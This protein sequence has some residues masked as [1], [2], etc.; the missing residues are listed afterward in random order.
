MLPK[1]G[2][3]AADPAPNLNSIPEACR[4]PSQASLLCLGV[5]G[6]SLDENGVSGMALVKLAYTSRSELL[7]HSSLW[8]GL[9]Y[10]PHGDLTKFSEP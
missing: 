9:L 7:E 5:F 1:S 10:I 3:V 2:A 8:N 4:R 6:L